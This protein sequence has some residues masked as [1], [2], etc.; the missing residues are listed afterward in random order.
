M[1]TILSLLEI[2]MV[3]ASISFHKLYTVDTAGDS[4][5]ELELEIKDSSSV[6]KVKFILFVYLLGFPT[7]LSCMKFWGISM[8]LFVHMFVTLLEIYCFDKNSLNIILN[9]GIGFGSTK[10][11]KCLYKK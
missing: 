3:N 1:E 4:E 2:S 10:V 9:S 6:E 8:Y 7:K 5:S 11:L